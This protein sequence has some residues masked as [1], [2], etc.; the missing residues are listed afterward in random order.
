MKS[1]KTGLLQQ[2][3]QI[4]RKKAAKSLK[5]LVNPAPMELAEQESKELHNECN[6]VCSISWKPAAVAN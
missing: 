3:T 2:A 1:Q 6:G 4:N 5:K